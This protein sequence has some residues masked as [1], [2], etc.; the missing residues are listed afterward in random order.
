MWLHGAMTWGGLN[1]LI[2]LFFCLFTKGDVMYAFILMCQ[3]V[4]VTI[5]DSV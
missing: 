1:R 2:K 4:W 3:C 5:L